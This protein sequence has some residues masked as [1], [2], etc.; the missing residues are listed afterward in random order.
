MNTLSCP[1]Y[2]IVPYFFL[3]SCWFFQQ[4]PHIW[5]CFLRALSDSTNDIPELSTSL[6][7]PVDPPHLVVYH[8]HPF[9][10]SCHR[11][12]CRCCHVDDVELTL[13]LLCCCSTVAIVCCLHRVFVVMLLA[14]VPCCW[15]MICNQINVKNSILFLLQF[16]CHVIE[17]LPSH[18]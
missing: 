16:Q 18:W 9:Y 5:L 8:L 15:M 17:K 10:M 3:T 6:I 13:P 12:L 14:S 7:L 1:A 4:S 11:L 2:Q